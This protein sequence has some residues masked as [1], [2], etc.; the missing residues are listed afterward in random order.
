MSSSTAHDTEVKRIDARRAYAWYVV[1]V[2]TLIY[3]ISFIDRLILNVIIEPIRLE[4]NL[5]DIQIGLINGTSFAVFYT[6]LAL[7]CGRIVDLVNRKIVILCGLL[8]WSVLTILSAFSDGFWE[9]FI[10]RMGVGVG[11]A[12]LTPAAFSI[13]AD[14][15]RKGE[16]GAALSFYG[17]GIYIGI[18]LVYSGGGLL[19]GFI[20]EIVQSGAFIHFSFIDSFST[21]RIVLV[22]VGVPSLLACFFVMSIREPQRRNDVD[23][24]DTVDRKTTVREVVG[25]LSEHSRAFTYYFAGIAFI[26]TATYVRDM[27]NTSFFLRTHSV[28]L[29]EINLWYG[30]IALSAGIAGILTGGRTS[31]YLYSKGVKAAPIKVMLFTVFAW[32]PFGFS[33]LLVP[34]WVVSVILI[35]PTVFFSSMAY[36]ANYAA[37]QEI[38]PVRMRG[39]GVSLMLIVTNILGLGIGPV[40]VAFLTDYIFQDTG[41]IRYSMLSFYIVLYLLAIV[42]LYKA[43]KPYQRIAEAAADWR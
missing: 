15:F 26:A 41:M 16:R 43:I 40:G 17:T 42:V 23:D 3:V 31:D 5:T 2:L 10:F 30:L 38:M 11:E 28:S 4:L 24:M 7:P 37:L 1:S 12:A 36:G 33:Y 39:I 22:L 21:W 34:S 8:I 9:L 29:A 6:L 32:M 25:Y 13:I 35:F 19:Y 18:F 27:W 14:Y 20:E